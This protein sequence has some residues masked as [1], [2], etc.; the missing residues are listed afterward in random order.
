M[1]K[2]RLGLAN[3]VS[4]HPPVYERAEE[5]FIRQNAEIHT[6]NACAPQTMP[7]AAFP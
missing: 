5:K 1:R 4:L 2:A 6:Q 7:R 3:F